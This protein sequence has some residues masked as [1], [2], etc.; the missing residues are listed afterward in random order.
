MKQ[1]KLC[2]DEEEMPA[3]LQEAVANLHGSKIGESTLGRD[4]HGA[5]LLHQHGRRP[6]C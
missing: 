5:H 3:N 1:R 2:E 6:A 4:F